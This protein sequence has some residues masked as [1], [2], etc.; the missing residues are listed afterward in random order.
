MVAA[1]E[2]VDAKT[3]ILIQHLAIALR[4]RSET[5]S[6]RV[7]SVEYPMLAWV[8]LDLKPFRIAA[9]WW[10]NVASTGMAFRR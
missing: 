10:E 6:R 4:L 2:I 5:E 9:K 7:A 3:V 8:V 1:G